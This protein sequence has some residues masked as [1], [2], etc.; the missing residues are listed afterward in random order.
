MFWVGT[1]ANQEAQEEATKEL[2]RRHMAQSDCYTLLFPPSAASGLRLGAPTPRWA[3]ARSCRARPRPREAA[4][5]SLAE[6]ER[7]ALAVPSSSSG[8]STFPSAGLH[9]L[10]YRGSAV[11][12][13]PER[14]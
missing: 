9:A 8:T 2:S 6:G 13:H 3:I 4:R 12:T 11:T 5:G 14:S 1:L 10:I 7:Q